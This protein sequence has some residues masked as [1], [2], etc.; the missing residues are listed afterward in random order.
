MKKFMKRR[1]L[2]KLSK[3]TAKSTVDRTFGDRANDL[4]LTQ[5]QSDAPELPRDSDAEHLQMHT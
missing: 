4:L 5:V 2:L 1:P 3:L